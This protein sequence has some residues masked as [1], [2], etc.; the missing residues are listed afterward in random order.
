MFFVLFAAVLL[1]QHR[2]VVMLAKRF[3]CM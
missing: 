2:N 3:W 1:A